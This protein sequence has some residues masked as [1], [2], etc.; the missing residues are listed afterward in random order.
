MLPI[1]LHARPSACPAP[2]VPFWPYPV[3]SSHCQ[4]PL[5]PF[6]P[7]QQAPRDGL[8]WMGGELVKPGSRKAAAYASATAL[9][10]TQSAAETAARLAEAATQARLLQIRASQIKLA[11]D[12]VSRSFLLACWRSLGSVVQAEQ[13]LGST[14]PRVCPLV[15]HS[16]GK[17]T[18]LPTLHPL[19]GYT[20]DGPLIHRPRS[21]FAGHR[22]AERGQPE[23]A[24]HAAGAGGGGGRFRPQLQA[25]CRTGGSC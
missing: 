21:P 16:S 2:A 22:P 5:P 6:T 13:R 8:Q 25:R 4:S 1:T 17:L 23:A 20:T 19:R 11:L 14:S 9:A 3:L 18:C 12:D 24:G 15:L 7:L 10:A